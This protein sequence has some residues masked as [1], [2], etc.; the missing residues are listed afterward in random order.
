[1]AE[2]GANMKSP[3]DWLDEAMN[4]Q[5]EFEDDYLNVIRAI[6]LDAIAHGEQIGWEKGMDEAALVSSK[7][8]LV[9][10]GDSSIRAQV[11]QAIIAARDVR[12]T[13]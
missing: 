7:A 5:L 4:G 12:K 8:A 11:S 13:K 10:R 1:M 3:E 9:A 2:R 6:Q